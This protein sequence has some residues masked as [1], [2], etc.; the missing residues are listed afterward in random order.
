MENNKSS[1]YVL[2]IVAIIAIVGLVMMIN[3]AGKA[4]LTSSTSTVD[5]AGE[6]TRATTTKQAVDKEVIEYT[7]GNG[8]KE[9][10]EE[11]DGSDLGFQESMGAWITVGN[12]MT[13]TFEGKEYVIALLGANDDDQTILLQVNQEKKTVSKNRNTV[14][15]GLTLSF[16][17]YHSDN[18]LLV[19]KA[20]PYTCEEYRY[21]GGTLS[22][23][24]SCKYNFGNCQNTIQVNIT[25]CKINPE[26]SAYKRQDLSNYREDYTFQVTNI[27]ETSTSADAQAGIYCRFSNSN[28][29]ERFEGYFAGRTVYI[30]DYYGTGKSAYLAGFANYINDYYYGGKGITCDFVVETYDSFNDGNE[31]CS[32]FQTLTYNSMGGRYP[33]VDYSTGIVYD[34][35]SQQYLAIIKA[36][37]YGDGICH[38]NLQAYANT[39]EYS[40][41]NVNLEWDVNPCKEKVYYSVPLG[42]AYDPNILGFDMWLDVNGKYVNTLAYGYYDVQDLGTRVTI[43]GKG[44]TPLKATVA[45]T[46]KI[47]EKNVLQEATV[48]PEPKELTAN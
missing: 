4:K 43:A 35:W 37:N 48:I 16:S 23:Y 25:T 7:C 11:C 1:M 17:D 34:D 47:A 33:S 31:L 46:D 28:N 32:D 39:N 29:N 14:I 26:L 44:Y 41:S 38:I 13:V 10:G 22:C 30:D 19:L 18:I 3:S 12:E 24:K 36:N 40:V 2:A 9:S 45:P 6:V 27:F 5:Q 8:F 21:N 20:D 42:I 15:A